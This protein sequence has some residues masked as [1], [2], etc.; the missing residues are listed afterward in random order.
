[1]VSNCSRAL[2]VDSSSTLPKTEYPAEQTTAFAEFAA[3]GP[4]DEEMATAR[5]QFAVAAR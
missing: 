3:S 4:T 1:L 5:K 2:W